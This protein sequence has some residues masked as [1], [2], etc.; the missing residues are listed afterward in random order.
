MLGKLIEEKTQEMLEK[1]FEEKTQKLTGIVL[2]ELESRK[3][4]QSNLHLAYLFASPIV[5]PDGM[6]TK[7]M[8]DMSE[9]NFYPEYTKH[10]FFTWKMLDSTTTYENATVDSLAENLRKRPLGLHLSMHGSPDQDQQEKR[11]VALWERLLDQNLKSHMIL[12]W[13][14]LKQLLRTTLRILWC[15]TRVILS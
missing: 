11:K 4:E 1:M 9:I 12:W 3:E 10:S 8:F 6:Q 13:R 2:K 7:N 15:W 14:N 5:M